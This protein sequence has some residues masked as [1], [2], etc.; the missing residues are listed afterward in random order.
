MENNKSG[1][2][3][4]TGQPGTA[5]QGH[6][7]DS[8]KVEV[9]NTIKAF[10]SVMEPIPEHP[11]EVQHVIERIKILNAGTLLADDC[12]LP[13]WPTQFAPDI[14]NCV[15][16]HSPLSD[17]MKVP[18]SNGRSYLLT[19]T[20]IFPVTALIRKCVNPSCMARYGY[21]TWKEGMS[22]V[23]SLYFY[24]TTTFK[25][26]LLQAF[27]TY[28]TRSSLHWISYSTFETM[29]RRESHQATVCTPLFLTQFSARI[30]T[31]YG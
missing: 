2:Y 10:L 21:S 3:F 16:C 20:T 30:W 31:S 23:I 15:L 8:E 28:P 1:D 18:G 11:H 12:G 9:C 7:A 25:F 22:F 4:Y 5:I 6:Q 24:Y 17:F 26:D 19:A 14:N 27:T 13:C 29:C